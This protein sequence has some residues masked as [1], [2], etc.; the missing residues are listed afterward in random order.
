MAAKVGEVKE[1]GLDP[2][3]ICL[4]ITTRINSSKRKWGICNEG[5][6]M[7]EPTSPR[8]E[9]P[10]APLVFELPSF[11]RPVDGSE[12]ISPQLR[13]INGRLMSEGGLTLRDYFASLAMQ[14]TLA[15]PET[16]AAAAAIAKWSYEQA[17]AMLKARK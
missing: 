15:N 2:A 17:D 1:P 13:G 16:D 11:G 6:V 7:S 9:P 5:N 3:P 12:F 14:G 8:P 10:P 4:P